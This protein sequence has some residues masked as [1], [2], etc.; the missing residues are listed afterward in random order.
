VK[1]V[2]ADDSKRVLI[3]GAKPRQVFDYAETPEGSFVLTPVKKAEPEVIVGKL[4]RKDGALV[5]DIP[6][7][8]TIDQDA[9]LK[10]IEEMRREFCE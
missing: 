8:Y 9:L 2:T 6:E 5:L 4:V 3:P 1:T 7:G 10:S